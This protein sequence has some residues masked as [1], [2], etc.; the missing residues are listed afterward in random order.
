MEH[1]LD[2]IFKPR[3]IAVIGASRQ[4]ESIGHMILHNLIELD[5]E[6]KVFPVNPNVDVVHSIKSFPSVL[7]IPD[8]VDLAIIGNIEP[9]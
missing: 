3:S 9:L 8:Q 4:K 6:G 7:D 2:D 5:F 1:P